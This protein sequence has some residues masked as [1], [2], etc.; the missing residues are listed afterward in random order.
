MPMGK[1]TQMQLILEYMSEF[2]SI[3]PLEAISDIGC[4]RLSARISD[5]KKQGYPIKTELVP[6]TNR[7]GKQSNV[8]RYSLEVSDG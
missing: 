5:L 7:R 8:A 3:T 6:L 1:P 2:G 4:Y